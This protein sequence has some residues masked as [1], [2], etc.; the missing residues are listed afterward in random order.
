MSQQ[1]DDCCS[2]FD[3]IIWM[4]R[5]QVKQSIKILLKYIK[6]IRLEHCLESP[7]A[8]IEYMID[9]DDIYLNIEEYKP[10]EER[11]ILI[12]VDDKI[13]NMLRNKKRQK[14]LTELFIE[15]RKLN[16]SFVVITQSCFA[17]QKI[18]EKLLHTVLL[19]KIQISESFN[20][21]QLTIYQILN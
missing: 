11:K 10:N 4:L 13:A 15:G 12:V 2:T 7:K 9:L 8:L 20:K 5:I 16:I 1:D 18:L 6:K 14:I 21:S 19:W 17:V 3:K